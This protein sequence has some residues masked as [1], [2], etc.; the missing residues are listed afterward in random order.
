[1]KLANKKHKACFDAWS[2][3][4]QFAL[5]ENAKRLTQ[6]ITSKGLRL[7]TVLPFGV[8]N[9]PGFFQDAMLEI[10][11]PELH[12]QMKDLDALLEIFID[13]LRARARALGT[14]VRARRRAHRD[15]LFDR[16]LDGAE[17]GEFRL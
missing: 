2:G 16:F 17:L 15:I 7:W 13:D 10:Y 4:N 3:F 11:G 14:R 1:M 8:T 5:T 6:I 9:G 12:A